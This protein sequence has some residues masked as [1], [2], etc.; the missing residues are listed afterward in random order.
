MH[1]FIYQNVETNKM[2]K[3]GKLVSD[4]VLYLESSY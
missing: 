4:I 2:L 1:T 3:T